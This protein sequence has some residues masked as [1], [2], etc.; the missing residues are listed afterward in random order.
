[1]NPLLI[2]Y[3]YNNTYTLFTCNQHLNVLN[4]N[5]TLYD[6]LNYHNV[7]HI[8]NTIMHNDLS[9]DTIQDIIDYPLTGKMPKNV[10]VVYIT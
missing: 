3:I 1:M 5:M 2:S 7:S 4:I 9:S 10:T 6:W 8:V